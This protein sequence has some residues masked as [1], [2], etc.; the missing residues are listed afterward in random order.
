[1]IEDHYLECWDSQSELSD[2]FRKTRTLESFCLKTFIN[3]VKSLKS[4]SDRRERRQICQ[5]IDE[6]ICKWSSILDIFI[7]KFKYLEHYSRYI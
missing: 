1:M 5:A 3:K 2:Y 7:I 4:T 6:F